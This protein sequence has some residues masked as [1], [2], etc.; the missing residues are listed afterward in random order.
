MAMKLHRFQLC[1]A[2]SMCE[3]GHQRGREKDRIS[4][5]IV[6]GYDIGISSFWRTT[7]FS[8]S[9]SEWEKRLGAN[10]NQM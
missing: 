10:A 8:F 4:I 6:Y 3:V 9:P 7:P 5:I 2:K 1:Q